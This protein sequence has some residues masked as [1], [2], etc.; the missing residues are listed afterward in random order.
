MPELPRHA[1][2]ST[3]RP[4]GSGL[5]GVREV[6]TPRERLAASRWPALDTTKDGATRYTRRQLRLRTREGAAVD[7]ED[8]R[9]RLAGPAQPP[10]TCHSPGWGRWASWVE[11]NGGY[12]EPDPAGRRLSSVLGFF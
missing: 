7:S 2:D 8:W 5:K 4:I 3:T 10:E 1:D 11:G 6:N 9:L 12:S